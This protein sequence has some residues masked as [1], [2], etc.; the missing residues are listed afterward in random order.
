MS[1][2]VDTTLV[3]GSMEGYAWGICTW[4]QMMHVTLGKSADFQ[5]AKSCHGPVTPSARG[6]STKASQGRSMT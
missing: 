6:Q 1:M 3:F 5:P 4:Q 2:V